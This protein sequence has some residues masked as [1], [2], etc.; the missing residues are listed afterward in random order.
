MDVCAMSVIF[1]DKNTADIDLILSLPDVCYPCRFLSSPDQK[2]VGRRTVPEMSASLWTYV[3][4]SQTFCGT[5]RSNSE[6][7]QR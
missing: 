7:L 3:Q 2:S 6:F 1:A 4:L 5:V